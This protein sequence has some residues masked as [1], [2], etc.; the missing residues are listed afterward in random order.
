VQRTGY[1]DFWELYK[2]NNLPAETKNYVP[3][4]IAVTLMAKN[5]KQYGLDDLS[6]DPAVQ[7]DTVST[8]YAVDLRLVSDITGASVQEIQSLN[9]S[10]LRMSTPPD[11]PF[12]LHVP[13]GTKETFERAIAEIPEDK[14]RYWRY[15]VLQPDDTME[16]I[17]HTYHVSASEIAF[18]NQLSSTSSDLSGLDSLVI[19]VAPASAPSSLR[20]AR[21]RTRR[22]DTLITV[23]DRFGVTVD[24]LRRWNHLTGTSVKEGRDLYVAEPARIT[25]SSR[26]RGK[27]RVRS[28]VKRATAH[29]AALSKPRDEGHSGGHSSAKGD[30]AVRGVKDVKD[31]KEKKPHAAADSSTKKKKHI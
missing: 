28:A 11:E 21:Y 2:R 16:Q 15:H 13:A 27:A 20:N 24:Q 29:P 8:D 6:P 3:I 30:H 19:P 4:I 26:G 9:P 1:A 31:V 25:G 5:P 18:V 23:A 14:R 22:G 10:L 12:D 17:A 7:E